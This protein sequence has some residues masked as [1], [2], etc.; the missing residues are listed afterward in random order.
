MPYRAIT[1]AAPPRPGRDRE[2]AARLQSELDLIEEV[3]DRF[4]APM[5]DDDGHF[6]SPSDRLVAMMECNSNAQ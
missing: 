6:L 3:L 4:D 5:M 1:R 2:K